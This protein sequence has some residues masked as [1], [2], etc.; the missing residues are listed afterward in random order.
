[1]TYPN[2]I[3]LG[4]AKAG[5]TSLYH[6]LQQHP[7]VYMSPVKEANYFAYRVGGD[8]YGRDLLFPIQSEGAY[9][10]LFD[11]VGD[12]LAIGEASPIYLENFDT[13]ASLHELLPQVKLIAI[14]RDPV[15]RALSSYAMRVRKGH[16]KRPV[17]AAITPESFYVQIGFYWRALQPYYARFPA[18]NIRVYWFDDLKMASEALLRDLFTFIGVDPEMNV[19][20]ETVHNSGGLPRR[21]WLNTLLYHPVLRRQLRP[22]TPDWLL[23]PIKNLWRSNLE[24]N[25]DLPPE[26]VRALREHYQADILALQAHLGRDLS[27]WLPQEHPV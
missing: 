6:Y 27:A 10:A 3:I 16:E 26:V 19:A 11:G 1:M 7:Q 21:R 2:F 17:E 18:E 13:A 5:T 4:A 12:E 22:F 25:P 20:S 8:P 24:G 9:R 14:L 15:E 23:R